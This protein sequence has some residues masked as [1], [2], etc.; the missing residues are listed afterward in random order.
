MMAIRL[1]RP[2]AA[3][4]GAVSIVGLL[5]AAAAALAQ[6][7]RH[8]PGSICITPSRWCWHYPPGRPGADCFCSTPYG[9]VK[10]KLSSGS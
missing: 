9:N 10:G 4:L 2:L 8:P 1:P 6:V 5:L 3:L 7:P